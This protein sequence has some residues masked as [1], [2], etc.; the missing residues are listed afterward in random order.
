MPNAYL[1][2]AIFKCPNCGGYYVE[3]SWYAIEL[4]SDIECGVCH[5]TFNPKA[6]LTDR[7]MLEVVVDENG[8]ASSVKI[9]EH[10]QP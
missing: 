10:I 2:L 9:I 3:A 7:I 1:D 4:E 6:N 8:K 5:T